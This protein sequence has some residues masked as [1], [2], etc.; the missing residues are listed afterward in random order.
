ML[1]ILGKQRLS[2]LR[3]LTDLCILKVHES[4]S[5][6]CLF[7]EHYELYK[8]VILIAETSLA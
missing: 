1:L 6:V 8:I 3:I 7:C 4:L 5:T 2:V